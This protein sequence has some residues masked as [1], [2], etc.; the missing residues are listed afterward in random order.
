M[1]ELKYYYS[2]VLTTSL[3]LLITMLYFC[4]LYTCKVDI[5]F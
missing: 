4:I 2:K 1:T 5:K 3:S